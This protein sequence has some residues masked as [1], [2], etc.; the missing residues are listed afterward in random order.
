ML[1]TSQTTSRFAF[2]LSRR[3]TLDSGNEL[4]A[5]QTMGPRILPP[6]TVLSLPSL[7]SPVLSPRVIVTRAPERLSSPAP[8]QRGS[9]D[10]SLISRNFGAIVRAGAGAAAGFATGGIG[11]AITSFIGQRGAGGGG[12]PGPATPGIFNMPFNVPGPG[13]KFLPGFGGTQNATA[14]PKGYHLNKHALAAGKRHGAQAAHTMCVRNR[15]IN[16][17]NARALTRSLRRLKRASKLVKKL[18]GVGGQRRIGPGSSSGGHKPGC[19]CFRCRK[20]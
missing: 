10:M 18:H 6:K 3:L 8:A 4:D 11:G 1:L 19:G 2:P 7:S 15:K 20:R 17:L 5:P 9:A 13:G 14:C 12:S 16:P